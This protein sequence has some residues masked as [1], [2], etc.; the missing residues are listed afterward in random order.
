MY[1]DTKTYQQDCG[2]RVANPGWICTCFGRYR[3]FI[4]SEDELVMSELRRVAANFVMQSAVSDAM[5][6]G[7]FNLMNH[8]RRAAIGYKIVLAVH[9]SVILEVPVEFVSEVYDEILPQCLESVKFSR[10]T[11]DGDPIPGSTQYNFGTDR[12]VF[13]RWGESLTPDECDELGIE[14]RFGK[15]KKK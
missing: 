2:N 12:K 4:A 8:P 11:L 15:K 3:R 5:N 7:L 9:D 1:P 13:Y 14:R 6:T 10:Y